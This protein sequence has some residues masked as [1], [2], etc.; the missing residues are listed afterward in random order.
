[1]TDSLSATVHIISIRRT[2][3]HPNKLLRVTTVYSYFSFYLRVC[4]AHLTK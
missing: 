4:F 1:M 3:I 2:E